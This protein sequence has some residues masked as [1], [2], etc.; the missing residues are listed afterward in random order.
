MTGV[1]FSPVPP[2][3]PTGPMVVSD[4]TK[5]SAKIAWKAPESDGGSPVT[6]Y[7]IEK[8]ETW[9][10]SWT[11]VERV[12]ADHLTCVL[13]HLQEGQDLYVRVKAENVAG[14]SKPLESEQAI[15][16]KSPYSELAYWRKGVGCGKGL[17]KTREI[18]ILF[19]K[20]VT[21][22]GINLSSDSAV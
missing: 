17:K 13:Q 12:P 20:W 19:G 21:L 2:S 8:R 5:T 16:P 18:E 3:E 15:M 10:T 4:V 1:A 22:S 11:L 7:T 6:H 9:K 14:L